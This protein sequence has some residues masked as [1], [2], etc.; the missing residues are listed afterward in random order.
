MCCCFDG[1]TEIKLSNGEIKKIK[2]IKP[3][4][5]V[6]GLNN[7]ENIVLKV[8]KPIKHF[9]N[10]YAI[11]D[12]KYFTTAEHP[13]KTKDGWASIEPKFKL[14]NPDTWANATDHIDVDCERINDKTEIITSE[15]T[16]KITSLKKK[17]NIWDFFKRVYNL[18]TT[19]N[20]TFYANGHL[21]H[22]KGVDDWIDDTI[23][24]TTDF[25]EDVYDFTKDVIN[26]TIDLVNDLIQFII[27]PFGF[28]FDQPGINDQLADQIPGILVNKEGAIEHVPIIYGTR[29][30]GGIRVFVSTN[31]ET[32]KYLYVAMVICE[33]QVNGYTKLYIDDNEVPLSTYA[34]GT[35]ATPTSGNYAGKLIAQFFDGRENQTASSLLQEAPGWSS[36]HILGGLAYIAL[37]FEWTGFNTSE[38]PNK[39]PYR[40]V[41]QVN[42]L[43]E[44]RKIFDVTT[45]GVDHTTAYENDAV[46]FTNNPVSI[47]LDY[48]RN[49]LYG[50]G[51]T[52]NYFDWETWK[53]AADLCNQT[54]N[55]TS[56]TS[57]PAYTCDAAVLTGGT[58]MDNCKLLLAGFNA[59]MPFQTGKYY[60]K[61]EHGGDDTD[62]TATPVNPSTVFEITTDHIVGGVEIR[63]PGKRDKINRITVTYVDPVADYQ[64]NQVTYPEDGST[65]D[66]TFLAED[67][68]RLD[69]TITYNTITNREMALHMAEMAVRR[70]RNNQGITVNVSTE[71]SNVS[72]GDLVR[73][74]NSTVAL[75][76]IF[77]VRS[78]GLNSSGFIQ[79][80]MTQHNSNDY[81]YNLQIAA[82][83]RPTIN[84]P[85]PFDIQPVTNLT[86]S[87]GQI[88]N[89][90][91]ADGG[92]IHRIYAQW[93]A[94]TDPFITE[95]IVQFKPVAENEY[96][97]AV[98]TSDTY[99]YITGA[100][101][102]SYDVRVA[103]KNEV[104]ARSSWV[105][106]T[107]TME[108]I[109]E[110]SEGASSVLTPIVFKATVGK[111]VFNS[112]GGL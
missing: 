97:T 96:T 70:S 69:K 56:T 88:Y 85:D 43:I 2:D 98:I 3:G 60:L 101:G 81:A 41:P 86:L 75:D 20:H 29:R 22:N 45:V 63:G 87:T 10:L 44:G 65:D 84:L 4:D 33:G 25:L 28:D 99:A 50:K 15:G 107:V 78:V 83:A 6:L 54:V 55:Y 53:T 90:Q 102:D 64:P 100:L 5:K 47:L 112:T 111:T 17:N 62:I 38:E 110:P 95:Y 57:G 58:I 14:L 32:N 49:P 48:M 36:N 51:L 68:I 26:K 104:N 74:T 13:F 39:N 1:E 71:A 82:P 105:N 73:I 24:A 19:G 35:Q 16:K 109:Y 46:T 93:T 89:L 27:S 8:E 103:A 80:A 66:I 92:T 18:K 67:G 91:G 76:G 34:H 11:N 106:A 77:R 21:V 42:T 30:A 52:N 59:L 72:V 23:D 79:M 9:R 108:D 7:E 12:D 61:I 37:R 40:G 94:S 31:G